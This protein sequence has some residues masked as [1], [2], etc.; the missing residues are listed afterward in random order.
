MKKDLADGEVIITADFDEDYSIKYADE[1]ME[2]HWK[3]LPGVKIFTSVVYYRH[4][5]EIIS[6]SYAVISDA[7]N[8]TTL[9]MAVFLDAI[10]KD[11]VDCGVC[12]KKKL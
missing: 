7:K 8:N 6:K 2:T 10:I 12:L 4:N 11:L 3:S 5:D 1:P 9:E